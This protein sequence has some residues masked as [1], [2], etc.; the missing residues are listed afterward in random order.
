M[1]IT[2]AMLSQTLNLLLSCFLFIF[3]IIIYHVWS[4]RWCCLCP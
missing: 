1:D 3:V 2:A 4:F